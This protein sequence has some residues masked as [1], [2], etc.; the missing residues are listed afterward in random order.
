MRTRTFAVALALVA[1]GSDNPLVI[2]TNG[3]AA[4]R[5][6]D[7]Y[8]ATLVAT[9]GSG[10]GYTW[11]IADGAL[12]DGLAL[13]SSGAISGT[14]NE[15]G[16]FSFT[17]AV[18]DGQGAT[19]SKAL[20][21]EV[22]PIVED[23]VRITTTMLPAARLGETYRASVATAGGEGTVRWSIDEGALPDGLTLT[24]TG[25]ETMIV[26]V[27]AA[28]GSFAFTLRATDGRGA[29]DTVA[30]VLAVDDDGGAL[31]IVTT[32]VATATVGLPY[33]ANIVATGG[34]GANYRW[35]ITGGSLPD[36]LTLSP[37]GTPDGVLA[38]TPTEEASST[39]TVTVSDDAGGEDDVQLVLEVRDLGL[40]IG[41][42][43]LPAAQVGVVYSAT[44][45]AGAGSGTG[46]TWS[47][48]G[49][50]PAGLVFSSDDAGA[51]ITGTPTTVE[52]TELTVDVTDDAGGSASMT[53][54]I[55]VYPR[56]AIVDAA[57]PDG[58]VQTATTVS[59]SSTGGSGSGQV[60]TISSGAPPPGMSLLSLPSGASFGGVP[61][62]AGAFEFTVRV[63]DDAGLVAS[64][65][66]TVEIFER[67][68]ILT[69][70]LPT[71]SISVA[72]DELVV[73]R[74]GASGARTWTLLG[75][76]VP[77]GLTLE[78]STTNAIRLSGTAIGFGTYTFELQVEDE[79]R[80]RA[81]A[82][83]RIV[84]YQPLAIR[85]Q[86]I[87]PIVTGVPYA[88]S[89]VADGGSTTGYVWSVSA[90][91]LPPGLTLQAMGTPGTTLSGVTNVAGSYP[92][93]IAVTDDAGEV[94]T[95][96]YVFVAVPPLQITTTSI[97]G[98]PICT[99]GTA[100]ISSTGGVGT[101]RSWTVSAGSLPTGWTL[102][103]LDQS[104]MILSRATVPGQYTFTLTIADTGGLTASQSY[105]V[106]IPDDPNA[107][108]RAVISGDI[109][110]DEQFGAYFLD[111]CGSEPTTPV[112]ISPPNGVAGD[113]STT[114][115]LTQL[116]PNGRFAAFVGDFATDG[117]DDVYVV[118]L[119][120]ATRTP[121]NVSNLSIA[122]TRVQDIF[123]SPASNRIA[124][125]ADA[126]V[127]GR[128]DLYLVDL[129][130]P[131]SPGSPRNISPPL[132]G[133]AND[134]SPNDVVWSPNGARIAY[135]ADA[136]TDG[137]F[138]LF[139]VDVTNPNAPGPARKLHPDL[140]AAEDCEAD[141]EWSSDS[142]GVLFRCDFV[143]AG[144]D[145]LWFT[146]VTA[147]VIGTARVNSFAYG[148]NEDVAT[149]GYGFVPGALSR[150]YYLAD[151]AH[152]GT[153]ELFLVGFSAQT[154]SAPVRVVPPLPAGRSISHV[155]WNPAGTRVAFR[156]DLDT[157]NREDLYV[158]DVSG[159]LP[160]IPTRV[161]VNMQP[162]GDIDPLNQD[163]ASFEWS[164]DGTRIAFIAD[165]DVDEV[166]QAY[167]ADVR[168]APYTVSVVSPALNDPDLDATNIYW[169]PTSDAIAVRGDFVAN[170][171]FE[172]VV[173]RIVGPL[174]FTP[175]FAHLPLLGASDIS[176]PSDGRVFRRDGLGLFF[177][178]DPLNDRETAIFVEYIPGAALPEQWEVSLPSGADVRVLRVER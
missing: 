130:N 164:P 37:T 122:G 41:P 61:T 70:Q 154:P 103:D 141:F 155:R 174:A 68:E 52:S 102:R 17:A 144:I 67:L 51:R 40:V 57:L 33:R 73:A 18:E 112:R 84:V 71:A 76:T 28:A 88:M 69:T 161:T 1:C 175:Q 77:L 58:Y 50:L 152:N 13:A 129:A 48:S 166:E 98:R 38:G 80:G 19:T 104:A 162:N 32:A 5:R 156:A 87:D 75:G 137:V 83:I 168:A 49:T 133:V 82:Q 121:I 110:I 95:R 107:Q 165:Y 142:R 143:A 127:V 34:S 178:G 125:I 44:I 65:T 108:R 26:G 136:T 169:S 116:S 8:S 10:A 62:T 42:A 113:V 115:D 9:G 21:L 74:G 96:D 47:T 150:A 119:D 12:P 29:F 7:A 91:A 105:V 39:I 171:R 11:R 20:A 148:A 153:N 23:G 139:A 97:A 147:P 146:D 63:E 173:T 167:V 138:E 176:A 31:T 149:N 6:G 15:A 93:T 124:Y 14:P 106:D 36:G 2:A 160:A 163:F 4:A 132:A 177:E 59:L 135:R 46:H 81:T 109:E 24:P 89:I 140:D 117:I 78:P 172:M 43:T 145:E 94:A 3:L 151:E 55:D 45:T 131:A 123:W 60:W 99:G 159:A 126:V 100:S 101:E 158:V 53:Y 27:P 72:Y 25:M 79:Y 92:V 64:R 85:P 54:R 22:E 35:A 90:G 66:Y 56:L 86:R 128:N 118:D 120:A 111:M 30:L 114:A 134:I 170:A 16:S 157:P